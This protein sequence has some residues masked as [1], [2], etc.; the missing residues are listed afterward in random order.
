MPVRKTSPVASQPESE[1]VEPRKTISFTLPKFAIPKTWTPILMG[2]LLIASFLLGMLF[3]K[4]QYMSTG[5]QYVAPSA[6]GQQAAGQ[7]TLAP[8]KPVNVAVGNLPVMGN[9]DAKVK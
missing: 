8:G 3:T 2:L 1:S 4:V 6:A 7:P 9:K 5:G